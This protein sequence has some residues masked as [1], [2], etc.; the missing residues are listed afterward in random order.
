M[1][2]E[3]KPYA[4]EGV[5]ETWCV[6]GPRYK[7]AWNRGDLEELYD[8]WTDP[9]ELQNRAGEGEGVMARVR[10]R[11]RE[12]LVAWLRE[13]EDPLAEVVARDA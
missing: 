6:V 12:A 9:A 11:M 2:S 10:E 8:T 13:T 1:F 4:G 5:V 7:Y 3:Y